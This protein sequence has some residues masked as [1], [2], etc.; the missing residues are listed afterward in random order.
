MSIFGSNAAYTLIPKNGCSTLRL[1]IAIA[2]GCIAG[3]DEIDWIHRNNFS[4]PLTLGEAFRASYTFVVLRCPFERLYSAFMDKIVD[5]REEAWNLVNETGR[6][7][8]PR[9]LSFRAFVRTIATVARPRMDIH[10]RPQ[11]DF[12]LYEDYDDWFS[13]GNF[14]HMETKLAERIDLTLVDSR[15]RLG[16]DIGA[17]TKSD[18]PDA[19]DL[20]AAELFNSKRAGSLPSIESLY[21]EEALAE[22]AHI[23][24]EDIDLYRS[25]IGESVTTARLAGTTVTATTGP[26]AA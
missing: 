18:V 23:Y 11:I 9:D 7:R 17:I 13:L 16:H 1:S 10:W 8:H 25:R 3:P 6:R 19:A 22:V 26:R 14:A 2:N 4:F 15:S 21:D 20:S 5:S 24:H 12:L